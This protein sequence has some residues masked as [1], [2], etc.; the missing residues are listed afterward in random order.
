MWSV[1]CG[2]VFGGARVWGVGC[3]VECGGA[4]WCVVCGVWRLMEAA[5][6]KRHEKAMSLQT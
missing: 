1:E 3:G 5:T 4:W 2:V 6:Q